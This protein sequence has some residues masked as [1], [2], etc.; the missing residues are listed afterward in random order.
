MKQSKNYFNR[1][2]PLEKSPMSKIINKYTGI[3]F[4][5]TCIAM[6]L[7][8][9]CAS[10][11]AL[12]LNRDELAK[13]DPRFQTVIAKEIPSLQITGGPPGAEPVTINKEGTN[14]YR[15]IIYMTNPDIL[16]TM[17]VQVNSVL[18][19]FVTAHVTSSQMVELVKLDGVQYIDAGEEHLPQ[20]K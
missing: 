20:K 19:N 11:K 1:I 7:M 14:V 8:I 9:R 6:S 17:G 13:L 15:A 16:R 5:L 3:I 18:P 2:T 10:N 4:Q 12:T